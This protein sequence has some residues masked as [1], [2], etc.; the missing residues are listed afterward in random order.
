[1]RKQARTSPET[2]LK[3]APAFEGI[4]FPGSANFEGAQFAVDANFIGAAF[5]GNASFDR[6]QFK[7]AA[8]SGAGFSGFASFSKTRFD[9]AAGFEKVWFLAK[10][11]LAP[12]ARFRHA[13][14]ASSATFAGARFAGAAEFQKAGFGSTT[15]DACEF[16]GDTLFTATEFNAEA[17]FE[18]ARFSGSL[19]DFGQVVFHSDA[20]FSNANFGR[21]GADLAISG[22]STVNFEAARFEKGAFFA[23]VRFIGG[24][25]FKDAVFD[26]AA[27][28]DNALFVMPASFAPAVFSARCS[29]K[30]A[31][32]VRTAD[33]SETQFLR[34]CDFSGG[35]FASGAR[36]DRAR[37][38]G[39]AQFESAEFKGAA[40]FRGVKGEAALV[41]DRTMCV[42]APDLTGG[43][44]A[45]SPALRKL[46]KI[47]PKRRL[48]GR[49]KKKDSV[50]EALDWELRAGVAPEEWPQ[51]RVPAPSIP[52][53]FAPASRNAPARGRPL[54]PLFVLWVLT[55][56]IFV[57]FY[58]SQRLYNGSS[59][60]AAAIS[61]RAPGS[62]TELAA[63]ISSAG[64]GTF[65]SGP[66]VLGNSSPVSEALVLS[67]KNALVLVP[68]ESEHVVHRV[69]GCLYGIE[70]AAPAIPVAVS[71]GALLQATL[72]LMLLASAAL[73]LKSR[74]V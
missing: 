13:K 10:S 52:E 57:P 17:G 33:F 39:V 20:R 46:V 11:D 64:R 9:G 60:N 16:E 22:A 23:R 15:F 29:F 65:D 18:K 48:W 40:S 55:I 54:L 69:Y 7:A 32:F 25:E 37:F 24:C 36:F 27:V 3:P 72:S 12:C 42:T 2:F 62:L 47:K 31:Q 49:W 21:S 56:A 30:G 41:F 51:N 45:V 19:V 34:E 59:G 43:T 68:W 70:N 74:A 73:R 66:C 35:K 26:G 1:M 58:L 63:L 44:F 53:R 14:F 4:T 67:V 28:F 6:A 38:V 61:L 8:F 5:G 50:A 71:L